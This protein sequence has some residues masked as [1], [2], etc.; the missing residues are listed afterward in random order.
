MSE[1]ELLHQSLAIYVS[2]DFITKKEIL[3]IHHDDFFSNHFTRVWT[4]NTIRKKNFWLNMLF[5][6]NEYICETVRTSLYK[7]A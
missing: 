2:N 4:E 6:I 3:K 7:A 1:D 5:K